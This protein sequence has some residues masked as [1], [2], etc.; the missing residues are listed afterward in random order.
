[1]TIIYFIHTFIF[2]QLCY[3][4]IPIQDFL[5]VEDAGIAYALNV[6]IYDYASIINDKIA[7]K[8]GSYIPRLCNRRVVGNAC[9]DI[10]PTTEEMTTLDLPANVASSPFEPS[11]SPIRFNHKTFPDLRTFLQILQ[12]SFKEIKTHVYYILYIPSKEKK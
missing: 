2:S 3:T 5:M 4:H 10:H 7:V 11:T 9:N 1:M 6:W 12:I 8:K